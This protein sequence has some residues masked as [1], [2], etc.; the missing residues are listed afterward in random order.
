MST[1]SGSNPKTARA[2]GVHGE[3]PQARDHRART[4]RCRRTSTCCKKELGDGYIVTNRTLDDSL[5]TVVTDDALAPATAYLYDRKAGTITKLFDQRPAL[6]KAP[7]VPMQS[8]EIKARDGLT[9]VCYLSLPPGSDTDGDGI[10]EAP[11]PLVLNVHGGP[12]ARDTWGFDTEHQW[13]ANRGYAV[14]VGEL[15]RLDRLRQEVRQRG[16]QGVGRQDARRPA[17]RRRVGRRSRRS[18]TADKV[19]II[20]GSYGGYAT[21]VGLTFTPDTFACGVDIVGPV[22]P[23]SRCSARSRRTGERSSRSSRRASAIRARRRA[24]SSSPSARRSRTSTRSR[25]RC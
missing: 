15:P 8:L 25:S 11:V 1:R 2:A 4:S 22:E 9:L 13:L 18:P 10:P 16:Q 19:A 7:L 24:R 14:L 20:G 17:R 23:A 3:L 5:W 6:A 21:L 12:W